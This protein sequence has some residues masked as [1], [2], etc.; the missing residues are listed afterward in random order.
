MKLDVLM[1]T[2]IPVTSGRSNLKREVELFQYG[3]LLFHTART[4]FV[5]YYISLKFSRKTANKSFEKFHFITTCKAD[6]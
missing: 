2:E 4:G 5:Q 3:G 1:Q 6:N